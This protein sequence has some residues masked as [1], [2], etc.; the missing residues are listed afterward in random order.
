MTRTVTGSE[1]K[2]VGLGRTRLE[3]SPERKMGR[4]N[5]ERHV[6]GQTHRCSSECRAQEQDSEGTRRKGELVLPREWEKGGPKSQ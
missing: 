3:G 4:S 2:E 6:P 5:S 1:E